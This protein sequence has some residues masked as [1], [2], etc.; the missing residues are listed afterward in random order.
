MSEFQTGVLVYVPLQLVSFALLSKWWRLAALPAHKRAGTGH[1][2]ILTD[3]KRDLAFQN[4]ECLVLPCV[5]M[6]RR[7]T[8]GKNNGFKHRIATARF[9]AS[10]QKT[11]DVT[12]D[13]DGAAFG[14][15][16]DCYRVWLFHVAVSVFF[17]LS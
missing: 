10:C 8:T 2:F 1:K 9:L 7:S 4:V 13:T 11:V 3:L 12:N 16:S 5:E 15:S 6:G 17:E 14:R